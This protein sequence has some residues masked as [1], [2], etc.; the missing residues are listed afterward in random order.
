VTRTPAEGIEGASHGA[1]ASHG[2]EGP[3]SDGSSHSEGIKSSSHSEGIKSSSHSE[4]IKSDG[5]SHSEG[6]E[7]DGEGRLTEIV[8]RHGSV[9]ARLSWNG[10]A[11]VELRVANAIVRGAIVDDPLLGRAHEIV[12]PVD[13]TESSTASSS[14]ASPDER[15]LTTMSTID[16]S[17]PTEIPA[18]AA[19]GALPPGAG[20]AI[21]N[22]LAILAQRAG[23]SELRYAGPYPTGALYATLA[24]SFHTTTTEEDFTSTFADRAARVARDPMPAVFVPAPHER[25]AILAR[26]DRIDEHDG[27]EA[28]TQDSDEDLTR[29]AQ[30]ADEYDGDELE[31]RGIVELREGIERVTLDGVVYARGNGIARIVDDIGEIKLRDDARDALDARDSRDSR[32]ALDARDSRDAGPRRGAHAEVWFADEVY[33]RVATFDARGEL[34]DG[35]HPIPPCEG[36]V[37]GKEFPRAMTDALAALIADLV[38]AGLGAPATNVLATTTLRWADLGARAAARVGGELHLHAALWRLAP[39]GM[40][41][42]ALAI[43]EALVPRP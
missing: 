23:V 20:G 12:A 37:L 11:L 7:S 25:L 43:V 32:D 10:R 1:G 14:T 4:G 15:V 36:D 24:R 35:P 40:A 16:W 8:D 2:V 39:R 6:I 31:V 17:R 26:V 27:H 19:P 18:I 33:A 9:H 30:D 29:G 38:P 22:V 28:S 5:S 3:E 21:I 41:R 42:L 34:V 13:A